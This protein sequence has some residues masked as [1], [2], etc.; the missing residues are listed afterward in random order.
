ML[1]STEGTPQ[2]RLKRLVEGGIRERNAGRHAVRVAVSRRSAQEVRR[3]YGLRHVVAIPNGVDSAT[4]QPQPREVA[5]RHLGISESTRMALFVGRPE[6][7]KRPQWAQRT[8]R[9]LGL[10]LHFAGSGTLDGAVPLGALN[11]HDLAAAYSAADLVLAPTAYE[12][13]S[14]A[15]LEAL[16]CQA[17][18][19]TTR[20]GWTHDLCRMLPVAHE[21]VS[22]RKDFSAF[23]LLAAN[24][25][26]GAADDATL[27]TSDYIRTSMSI[28]RFGAAWVDL[29]K[30]ELAS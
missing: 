20:V 25:L 10:T 12:G 30:A 26:D 29:I 15:I 6:S 5:R 11:R 4:F 8:A 24:V 23:Q 9:E 17:P 21:F 22:P 16:A 18:L 19:V 2:W 7:R 14:F 28:D 27:T 3:W 1:A 13:C